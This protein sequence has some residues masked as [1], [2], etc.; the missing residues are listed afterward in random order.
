[1]RSDASKEQTNSLRFI[2]GKRQR[3]ASPVERTNEFRCAH[4]ETK[5]EFRCASFGVRVRSALSKQIGT[6]LR[7]R[8]AVKRVGFRKRKR[9]GSR[10]KENQKVAPK[11]GMGRAAMG[12]LARA[13]YSPA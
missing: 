6:P 2:R 9:M 5:N 4:S 12:S 11:Q 7:S 13:H 10:S 3:R 8:S 1:M